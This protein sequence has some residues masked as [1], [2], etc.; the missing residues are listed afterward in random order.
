MGRCAE[1]KILVNI[2]YLR[3]DNSWKGEEMT[4]RKKKTDSYSSKVTYSLLDPLPD[5]LGHLVTV[6][7][8]HGLVDL[9]TT[10]S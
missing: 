7:L 6:H 2:T 4:L 1:Q 10:F 5:D 3:G 8:N 9:D